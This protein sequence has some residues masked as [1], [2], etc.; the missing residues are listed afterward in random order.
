V[1][2]RDGFGSVDP[3]VILNDIR[4]MVKARGVSWVILDHLSILLSGNASDDER[5]MIDITMT[6][7]RSFVEETG[8]GMIL[9]S[10]LRRSHGDKGPEDGTAISLQMLR[11]SHS[12]VQLSDLVICL[13]R[14]ITAGDNLAELVVL[15]NRFNGQT[16]NAGLLSYDKET[17]RLLEVT[18]PANTTSA[19]VTYDDF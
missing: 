1:F 17:G 7:L 4:F 19:P 3:D 9:I 11:G 8:I 5:K 18:T 14:N 6:K 15:K 10:H 2:L 16:G 13:Q 12:I